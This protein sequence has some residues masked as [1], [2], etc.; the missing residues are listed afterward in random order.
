MRALKLKD[1]V[2]LILCCASVTS[3]SAGPIRITTWN[4]QWFPNGGPQ[5][6]S[7]R[8]QAK[9]IA[10]A[11]DVVRSINPDILLLQEVKDYNTCQRLANSIQPGLYKVAICSAFKQ[12]R[13]IGKQQVAIIA[14]QDAQAAWAESWLSKERI[15]PPRGF[16]FAWFKINGREVG[17][18]S[19][20]LKS[21]LVLHR[22]KDV[23][24]AVDIQKREVAATQLI[25]HMH[26]V[27][28][29]SMPMITSFVVGGDFNTNQDQK[30]FVDEKTLTAFINDGFRSP[31][32][33]LP[34]LERVTHPGENQYPDATFDYLFG[35]NIAFGKPLVTKSDVSDHF[36]ATCDFE[37]H[38]AGTAYTDAITRSTAD[39]R[40]WAHYPTHLYFKPGMLLYGKTHDGAYMTESEALANGFRPAGAK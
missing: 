11:A 36:P 33:D 18:Y 37:V 17:V 2:L 10:Q 16:A 35:K 39:V 9:H 30:E 29:K 15:D 5:E 14:K 8:E 24:M 19:V 3:A 20:H 1:A 25:G 13:G 40:V 7:V 38:S 27:I 31:F 26:G 22:N 23:E 28:A 32:A 21:N 34:L 6:K 12:G 4:L